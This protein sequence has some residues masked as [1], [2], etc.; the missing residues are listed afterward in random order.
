MMSLLLLLLEA[1]CSSTHPPTETC[2]HTALSE[3]GGRWI[4][5]CLSPAPGHSLPILFREF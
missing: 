2:V 3:I 5:K 1:P 4:S